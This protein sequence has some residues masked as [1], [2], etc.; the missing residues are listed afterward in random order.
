MAK[1]K[2]HMRIKESVG[3]SILEEGVMLQWKCW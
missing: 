2:D 1:G 3:E